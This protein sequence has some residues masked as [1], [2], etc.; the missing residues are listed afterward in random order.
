MKPDGESD[1]PITPSLAVSDVSCHK[2]RRC[3]A[4][5]KERKS[6]FV[7]TRKPE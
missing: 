3:K 2:L 6:L 5:N 4:G 1:A 7:R